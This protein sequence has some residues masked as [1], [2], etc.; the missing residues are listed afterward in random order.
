MGGGGLGQEGGAGA[1]CKPRPLPWPSGCRR[2][3]GARGV[4]AAAP[5]ATVAAT[6]LSPTHPPHPP[7]PAAAAAVKGQLDKIS[8]ELL[9]TAEAL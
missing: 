9:A 8:T 2:T 6:D 5:V 7:T 3:P 4:P 1:A